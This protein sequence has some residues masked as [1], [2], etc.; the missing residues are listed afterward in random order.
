M[1]FRNTGAKVMRALH[2][3]LVIC[4]CA[5]CVGSSG[6]NVATVADLEAEVLEDALHTPG[7][8]R[9][10]ARCQGGP[11]G[12]PQCLRIFPWWTTSRTLC[13]PYS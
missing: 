12:L 9:I 13:F 7:T 1:E 5:A 6:E 2:A 10:M 4:L 11:Q 8:D 3:M